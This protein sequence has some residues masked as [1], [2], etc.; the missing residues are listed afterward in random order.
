MAIFP[1]PHWILDEEDDGDGAFGRMVA[2]YDSRNL[3][4]IARVVELTLRKG[5]QPQ[6]PPKRDC[7]QARSVRPYWFHCH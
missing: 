5:F 4:G 3:E 7:A 6:K 2:D 1:L